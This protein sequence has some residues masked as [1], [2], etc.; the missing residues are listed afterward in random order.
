MRNLKCCLWARVGQNS[1]VGMGGVFF[2]VSQDSF[3]RRKVLVTWGRNPRVN[4]LPAVYLSKQKPSL[5]PSLWATDHMER[6]SAQ[7]VHLRLWPRQQP[8]S[9][10]CLDLSVEHYRVLLCTL[11]FIPVVYFCSNLSFSR[12]CV[13]QGKLWLW[14]RLLRVGFGGGF[15]GGSPQAV[16]MGLGLAAPPW[17]PEWEITVVL[18]LCCISGSLEHPVLP[19]FKVASVHILNSHVRV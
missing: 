18:T 15:W 13:W 9:L 14:R 1:V 16:D 11:P 19:F 5:F 4:C 6:G 3:P 17:G 7:S 8:V 10:T 12:V 2:Q